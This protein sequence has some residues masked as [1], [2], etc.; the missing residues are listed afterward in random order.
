MF[1]QMDPKV[2]ALGMV[3][4]NFLVP[5][6]ANVVQLVESVMGFVEGLKQGPPV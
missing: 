4:Q 2:V 5:A 1:R 6:Q 3:R